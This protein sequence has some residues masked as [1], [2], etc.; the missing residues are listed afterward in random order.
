MYLRRVQTSGTMI[1]PTDALISIR[2]GCRLKAPGHSSLLAPRL[3]SLPETRC[4]SM[5]RAMQVIGFAAVASADMGPSARQLRGYAANSTSLASASDCS[6]FCCWWPAGECSDC[7][8]DWNSRMYAPGCHVE[9]SGP[10][11]GPGKAHQYYNTQSDWDS[12]C[13]TRVCGSEQGGL[14]SGPSYYC[15]GT[16][17]GNNNWGSNYE[18]PIVNTDTETCKRL[19][20]MSGS[21]KCT[22]WTV[23]NNNECYLKTSVGDMQSDAGVQGSGYCYPSCG[24]QQNQQNNDGHNYEAKPSRLSSHHVLSSAPLIMYLRR[25]QTFGTMIRPIDALISIRFGCRLK[26]PGHSSLLAP[27]LCSACQRPAVTAWRVRCR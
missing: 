8:T 11:C 14:S 16:W 17:N 3:C 4:D 22:G 24:D 6:S 13:S 9:C 1:R 25:V 20:G 12:S 27:R 18:G 23:T 5:A 7:G 19:C 26:A 10:N 21:N 15:G 2:F